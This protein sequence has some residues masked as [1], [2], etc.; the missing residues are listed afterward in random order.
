MTGHDSKDMT[1]YERQSEEKLTILL[2]KSH[3]ICS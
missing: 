1:A 3:Q 2:K